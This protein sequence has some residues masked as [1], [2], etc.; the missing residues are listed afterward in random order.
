MADWPASLPSL[1]LA[2]SYSETTTSGKIHSQMSVGPGK[3]RR[4]STAVTRTFS[5][6]YLLDATQKAA[7]ET[8]YQTTLSG[9][10][11]SFNWTRPDTGATV[12]ARFGPS[13]PAYSLAGLD[14]YASMDIEVLP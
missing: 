10:T 3:V 5:L 4:R 1:P 14:F 6:V 12:T 7:F 8:F 13:E 2:D 11:L 9:G